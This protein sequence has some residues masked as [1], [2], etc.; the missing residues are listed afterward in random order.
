MRYDLHEVAGGVWAAIVDDDR[1]AVGNAAIVD[2][3]DETIVFDTTLS[4]ELADRLREDAKRLTG[5]DPTVL[6]NSHWHGDHT[7][8]NQSFAGLRIVSTPRTKELVETVGA[9]RL[10]Q[11]KQ[12]YSDEFPELLQVEPTPPT[13]TFDELFE[14]GR[15]EVV[16]YGGGHTESDAVL[17]LADVGVLL[18]ADL[19]VIDSHAWVGDGNVPSWRRILQLLEDLEPEVIVPGH[20]PVGTGDDIALVD[21]YLAKLLELAPG[22]PMP[23][24]FE[25]LAHPDV[26]ERNLAALTSRR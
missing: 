22:A 5:R 17:W 7:L 18:A 15:A 8:G 9:D 4:V 2:A 20:G 26:F 13:E 24:E 19:V 25:D 1:P 6:V 16:T 21:A 14:L 3:G 23:P 11:N 10:A 12:L